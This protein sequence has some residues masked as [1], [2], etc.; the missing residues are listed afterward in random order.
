MP[1]PDPKTQYSGLISIQRAMGVSSSLS[2]GKVIFLLTSSGSDAIAPEVDTSQYLG[3][4]YAPHTETNF[5]KLTSPT[6]MATEAGAVLLPQSNG[7]IMVTEVDKEEDSERGRTLER[8]PRISDPLARADSRF[9]LSNATLDVDTQAIKRRVSRSSTFHDDPSARPAIL[10]DDLLEPCP[11]EPLCQTLSEVLN[12]PISSA[13]FS[14]SVSRSNT[15]F[16]NRQA[17]LVPPMTAA[18]PSLWSRSN[19]PRTNS[20][21]SIPI[22]TLTAYCPLRL[23]SIPDL[24][25]TAEVQLRHHPLRL[26]YLLRSFIRYIIT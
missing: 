8:G 3:D 23:P 9:R 17:S 26:R 15:D 6:E 1:L 21:G 18:V 25:E 24:R 7:R 5:L 11:H 20:Q 19:I 13:S 4:T 16:L 14:A 12:T 10:D 22:Q 2:S